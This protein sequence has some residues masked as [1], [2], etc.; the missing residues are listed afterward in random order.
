MTHR[1][2][3]DAAIRGRK[4]DRVPVALWR[5][6][7]VDDET[8]DGLAQSVTRFQS[9][10]DFDLVKVTHASGYPA[11]AWGAELVA[12]GNEEG[13]RNY[14]RRP[15]VEPDDWH[16]LEPLAAGNEVYA[17]EFSALEKV[18]RNVGPDVHVLCTVFS[19]LTIAKQ[20][21]SRDVMLRHLRENPQ[22]LEAGLRTVTDSTALFAAESLAHGAD[23]IFFATQ[24]AQRDILAD[25]EYESFG[26]PFD[27]AV[28]EAARP[29]ADVIL[30]HLHGLEPMYDLCGRY[31]ADIVNWHDRETAPSLAEGLA[32]LDR[33]AVLGGIGRRAPLAEGSPEE[34]T[35][36][37]RQAIEATGARRLIVGA[38]CV[39][40]VTTPEENLLALKEAVDPE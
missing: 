27:L 1:E 18:R 21:A 13:T 14:L 10:Y 4:T 6:F 23:G 16:A 20:L 32:Q 34:V 11:E 15:V 9:E 35:S 3:I 7:P 28:L 31:D 33:G 17:R 24:F 5:H 26:V 38:G 2:R 25:E 40:L 12:A 19:P 29:A 8:A 30:L 39:T 22:D 37:A 36:Q